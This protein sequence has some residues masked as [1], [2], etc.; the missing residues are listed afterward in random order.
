MNI[1]DKNSNEL[2]RYFYDLSKAMILSFVAVPIIQGSLNWKFG[3][4]GTSTTVI[5]LTTG[6]F[7]RKD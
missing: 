4:A 3:L 6:I 2:S 5:L 1:F 7:L